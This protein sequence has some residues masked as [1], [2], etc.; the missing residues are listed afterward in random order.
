M[1]ICDS[2]IYRSIK[3]KILDLKISTKI[4]LFYFILVVFTLLISA[5]LYQRMYTKV[6][7]DKV[8]EVAMQNL[9]SVNSNINSIIDNVNSYSKMI[10]ANKDIQEVL[11]KGN[12]A[13]LGKA[14]AQGAVDLGDD[15]EVFAKVEKM[16]VFLKNVISET[17]S[18]S[19]VYIFDKYRNKY[20][21][22]KRSEMWL[23]KFNAINE[24]DWYDKV[25]DKRGGY[26]LSL[27][28]GDIFENTPNHN[29][30]SMIRLVRDIETFDTLGILIINIS[31]SAFVDLYSGIEDKPD[32]GI[33]LLDENNRIIS[34]NN[35]VE[36]FDIEEFILEA[37]DKEY[38]SSIANISKKE[39]LKSFINLSR[40][41]LKFIS[42]MPFEEMKVESEALN[43]ITFL[44]IGVNGIM[45]FIGSVLI[46][47]TITKPIKKL[48]K[49]MRGIEKKEFRMVEIE[50]GNDEIGELKQDYNIMISEIQKLIQ[51][52]VEEQRI[53]RKTELDILQAQVKP[54][55]LYNTL[56]AMRYLALSGKSEELYESLEALGSYYRIS[57]S[58]GQESI[59]I[60]EEIDILKSYLIL[61]K[62][63]YG[64]IF[65]VTYDIDKSAYEYKIP[66]LV[67]QPL[68]ENSIYHGIKPKGEPGLIK[69][70]VRIK[71]EKIILSVEDDGVGMSEEV[72]SSIKSE[73][74]DLNKLSFG[75][76]GT[77]K[78]LKL[79]YD[80]KDNYNI[81]DIY[82]VESEKRKGTKIF[83]TIPMLRGVSDE[84]SIV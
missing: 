5:F 72:L 14:Y 48:I 27:N 54:H 6:M 83:I 15:Q 65:E 71:D 39:Y 68:V 63:R 61:Q 53:K 46:S 21:A 19:S 70:C 26:I 74:L 75:L 28:A 84:Q 67:L 34:L 76:K 64:D 51:Q 57:L 2:L 23:K 66:K 56:D 69:I 25:Y 10:V 31:D 77:I 82:S 47:R 11:I 73:V 60:K 49:S 8:S 9:Y 1:K 36:E 13:K 52:T 62:L 78:R 35:N 41:N 55:F 12:D 33:F 42:L 16:N 32:S 40:Y 58:K 59:T 30:V 22:D 80:T 7:S 4:T 3:K 29:F 45:L 38:F 79:F 50:T 81:N 43:L 37:G 24:A 44:I 17:P 20:A 18:I